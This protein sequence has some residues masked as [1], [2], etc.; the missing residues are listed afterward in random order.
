M[1]DKLA[2]RNYVGCLL[3]GGPADGR[4]LRISSN[5]KSLQI[6]DDGE[7]EVRYHV[8]HILAGHAIASLHDNPY[9]A[10]EDLF[11]RYDA[12]VSAVRSAS[13]NG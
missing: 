5:A 7:Q 1:A 11:T 4:M 6:G 3:V 9:A 12:A 2:S 8:F 10:M 13:L